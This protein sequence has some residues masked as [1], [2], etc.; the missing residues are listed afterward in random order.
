MPGMM[1]TV[2][3]LGLNDEVVF[4]LASKS[5]ER[6]AF[7]SYR[8]FLDMFGDVVSTASRF[9]SLFWLLFTLLCFVYSL[10]SVLSSTIY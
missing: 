7:D 4:G 9:S 6:F 1:D 3:N 5:G 2:L 10:L 8:R